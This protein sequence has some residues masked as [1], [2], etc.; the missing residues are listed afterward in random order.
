MLILIAISSTIW[1]WGVPATLAA[2][3]VALFVELINLLGGAPWYVWLLL[4][5]SLYILWL[6]SFLFFSGKMMRGMGRRFPKPRSAIIP[7]TPFGKLRTVFFGMLRKGVIESLPL[8]PLLEDG[9]WGRDLV[10]RAYSPSLHIGNGAQVAA[11]LTDPDL[12]EVGELAIL[13]GGATIGAH[14]W[15]NLPNGKRVLVTAPVKIGARAMVGGYC[16]VS[17]GCQIGEDAI[18]QP[19]SYLP[20]HTKVPAG[21]IWGGRPA[22][23]IQKR[24][25]GKQEA[26]AETGK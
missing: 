24:T 14:Y 16:V 22:V 2:G 6:I 8:V 18:I 11:K 13:G 7:G 25:M 12:I 15:Y 4:S 3:V 17:M 1:A 5:P 19:H 9:Y 23:F 21:E 26:A 10:I 20:P